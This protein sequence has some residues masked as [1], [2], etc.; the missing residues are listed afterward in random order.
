MGAGRRLGRVDQWIRWLERV[1]A[2]GI[3]MRWLASGRNTQ[4]PAILGSD[5]NFPFRQAPLWNQDVTPSLER[6]AADAPRP[7][8]RVRLILQEGLGEV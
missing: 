5:L 4:A 7:K 3:P 1:F 8:A 2:D 6:M